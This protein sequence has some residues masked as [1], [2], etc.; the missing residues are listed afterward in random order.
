MSRK[1]KI[2][3][4]YPM[5]R[6]AIVE[7]HI[8]AHLPREL[9]ALVSDYAYELTRKIVLYR[10][11]DMVIATV[12]LVYNTTNTKLV[13]LPGTL[14]R[15]EYQKTNR[16]YVSKDGSIYE[17]DPNDYTKTLD[18]CSRGSYIPTDDNHKNTNA[19]FYTNA[20]KC[21]IPHASHDEPYYTAGYLSNDITVICCHHSLYFYVISTKQVIQKPNTYS[22]RTIVYDTDNARMFFRDEQCNMVKMWLQDGDI[23]IHIY[24]TKTGNFLTGPVKNAKGHTLLFLTFGH[25]I[26]AFNTDLDT[27]EEFGM[28]P[29]SMC[30]YTVF[31]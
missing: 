27:I 24:K 8:Y 19:V 12:D 16:I 3:D 2:G 26:S 6:F 14:V 1:R 25:S 23:K 17:L 30:I 28:L 13:K 22:P 29:C 4:V 10:D 31:N 20:M 11:Y 9:A 18:T 15:N 21:S 7:E 5:D